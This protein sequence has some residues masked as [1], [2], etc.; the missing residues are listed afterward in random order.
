[1]TSP[2]SGAAG[3]FAAMGLFKADFY[4][5]FAAGFVLGALAL[6]AVLG[7]GDSPLS[8]NVVPNAVAA[9]AETPAR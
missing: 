4:R 7:S 5:S 9:P 1:M 2:A 8:S 6:V 3:S